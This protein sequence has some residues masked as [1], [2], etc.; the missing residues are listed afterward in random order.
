MRSTALCSA[1]AHG[2]GAGFPYWT[3]FKRTAT[4]PASP[5]SAAT[6]S[7]KGG[8]G[9]VRLRPDWGPCRSRTGR[10]LRVVMQSP[11]LWKVARD[12]AHQPAARSGW[13]AGRPLH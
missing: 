11:R 12:T 7:R 5:H 10:R 13:R 9:N 1:L 2:K 4:V 3:R 8:I 6:P